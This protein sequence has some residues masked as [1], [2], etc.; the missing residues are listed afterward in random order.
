MSPNQWLSPPVRFY[1]NTGSYGQFIDAGDVAVTGSFGWIASVNREETGDGQL[2]EWQ[3]SGSW[4]TR[5]WIRY[6][7]FYV[8]VIREGYDEQRVV[9]SSTV[10]NQQWY[11]MALSYDMNAEVVSMWVDGQLSQ[12]QLSPCPGKLLTPDTA[13]I[14]LR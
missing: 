10:I 14:N 3:Y 6:D 1:S 8:N 5:I 2:M 11:T 4:K 9:F 7:A 13:Y 12:T